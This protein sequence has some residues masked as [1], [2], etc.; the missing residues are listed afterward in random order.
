M[1]DFEKTMNEANK[2]ALDSAWPTTGSAKPAFCAALERAERAGAKAMSLAVEQN[3]QIAL[4]RSYHDRK[5]PALRDVI[6]ENLGFTGEMQN[7]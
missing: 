6:L 1:S 5:C 7:D 3:R 4:A 2:A